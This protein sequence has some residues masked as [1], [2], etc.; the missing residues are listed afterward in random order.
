MEGTVPLPCRGAGPVG[1]P[2]YS[3]ILSGY[4]GVRL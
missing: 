3:L 1:S 4:T 2:G